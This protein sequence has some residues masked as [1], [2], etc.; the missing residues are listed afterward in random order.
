MKWI[1]CWTLPFTQSFYLWSFI[2]S[3]CIHRISEQKH[4]KKTF[5]SKFHKIVRYI[6][7]LTEFNFSSFFLQTEHEFSITASNAIQ[8]YGIALKL[9]L[10]WKDTFI[11]Q[12]HQVQPKI[13]GIALVAQSFY[14]FWWIFLQ[15]KLLFETQ[16]SF[17]QWNEAAYEL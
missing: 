2:E 7:T 9:K 4:L 12:R 1:E 3:F 5:E 17:V 16:K 13:F 10:V 11:I 6:V 14:R 15:W 8:Y